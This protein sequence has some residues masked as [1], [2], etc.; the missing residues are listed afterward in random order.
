MY[1]YK[2]MIPFCC[3]ASVFVQETQKYTDPHSTLQSAH[4]E[5]TRRTANNSSIIITEH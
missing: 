3:A 5:T 4:S 2:F 1:M